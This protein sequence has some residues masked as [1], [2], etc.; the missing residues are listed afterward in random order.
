MTVRPVNNK[1]LNTILKNK[2]DISLRIDPTDIPYGMKEEYLERYEGV[3]SEILNTTRFDEN[4]DLSTTYIGKLRMTLGDSLNV[5]ERFLKTE[6]GYT[7]GKLLDGTEYQILLDTVASKSFMLKSHYLQ[8][9]SLH[10]MP[11]FASKH[12]MNSSR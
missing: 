6:Q 7:V 12:T 1:N 8:C 11:K 4:T 10:S 3:I 9:K 2:D 5:E